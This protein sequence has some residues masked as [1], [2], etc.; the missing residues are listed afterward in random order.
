M[1]TRKRIFSPQGFA[2]MVKRSKT[3]LGLFTD[4]VI[5][6]GACIIEYKGR[7]ATKREMRDNTGKYL[8]WVD[9]TRM[10]NGISRSNTARYINHACNPNCEIDIQNGKIFI[11]S[12][13]KIKKGEE[14]TFDYGDEYFDMHIAPKGCRCVSCA[15]S[16]LLET[17]KPVDAL[18]NHDTVH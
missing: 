11:F 4:D 8:F 13:K 12:S 7:P 5:P 14:L 16:T 15:D 3:G 9:D 10:I 2:L 17:T 18:K 1:S 6:K